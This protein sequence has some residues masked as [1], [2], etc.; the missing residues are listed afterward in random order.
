MAKS[1]FFGFNNFE[2]VINEVTNSKPNLVDF[3]DDRL[4]EV[5][6]MPNKEAFEKE[7]GLVSFLS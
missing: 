6:T 5:I 7:K 3:H 2:T 1:F 4:I